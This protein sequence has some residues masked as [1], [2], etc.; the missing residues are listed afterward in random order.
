MRTKAAPFSAFMQESTTRH[1]SRPGSVGAALIYAAAIAITAIMVWP[2]A[3]KA[4]EVPRLELFGG[5]SYVRFDSKTF[6]FSDNSGLNG[7]DVMAAGNLTYGFGVLVEA[8][9]NYD[10]HMNFRDVVFG[11]QFL[12]PRGKTTFFGHALFGKG[13]SSVRVGTGPRD[14][15]IVVQFGGGIDRDITSHFAI[16]I[17]QADYFHTHLFQQPQNNFRFS[18]GL[19]YHWGALKQKGRQS[20]AMQS[21]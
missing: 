12:F 6:G 7:F 9:G 13:E 5:Y 15:G 10:P 8:S 11:P 1:K 18:T 20:P 4:Q 2:L 17:I 19:V 3:A 14:T 21:P 16:R